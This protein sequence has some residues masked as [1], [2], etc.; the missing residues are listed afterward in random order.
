MNQDKRKKGRFRDVSS[1]KEDSNFKNGLYKRNSNKSF[2]AAEINVQETRTGY[3]IEL[4]IPGYVKDD[5]NFYKCSSGLLITTER[6]NENNRN[7]TGNKNVFRHSYCYASAYFRKEVPLPENIGIEEF[8]YEYE[9]GI[10]SID[11]FKVEYL[12]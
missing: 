7:P 4:Y 3:H 11:L 5:F 12:N 6:T 8:S 10:L 1:L 2:H 9:D